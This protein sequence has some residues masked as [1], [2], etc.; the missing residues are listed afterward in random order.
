MSSE[1]IEGLAKKLADE[2]DHIPTLLQAA[3]VYRAERNPLQTYFYARSALSLAPLDKGLLA[4][5]DKI[6]GEGHL[7]FI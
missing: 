4:Q 2:P 7:E 1:S 3:R 6:L 5:V